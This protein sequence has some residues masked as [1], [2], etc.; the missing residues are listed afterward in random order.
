MV[1]P[2]LMLELTVAHLMSISGADHIELKPVRIVEG[3]GVTR[4][5]Y[6]VAS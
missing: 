6:R 5:R 4:L 1:T 2:R 3:E